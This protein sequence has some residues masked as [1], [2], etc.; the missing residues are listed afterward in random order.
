MKVTF[1]QADDYDPARFDAFYD[2]LFREA[3][4]R[5]R[6]RDKNVDSSLTKNSLNG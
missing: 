6:A 4:E 2:W 1:V 5:K 3:L